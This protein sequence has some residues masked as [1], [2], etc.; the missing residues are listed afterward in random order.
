MT[1]PFHDIKVVFKMGHSRPLF[2]Y[3]VLSINSH[4]QIP[5]CSIKVAND[6][7]RTCGLRYQKQT[8]CQLCH[9]YCP[10]QGTKSLKLT[11]VRGETMRYR[12]DMLP[13]L[14][15]KMVTLSGSPSKCSMYFLTHS[16]AKI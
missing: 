7:I 3:F 12:T 13:A 11:F 2:L 9:N 16:K 4:Q 10:Y 8:R 5:K 15:P 1:V 6:W 14:S